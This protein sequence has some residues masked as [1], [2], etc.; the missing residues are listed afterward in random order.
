V[1]AADVAAARAQ[2]AGDG[3]A[4][5]LA[6]AL[7]AA[8]ASLPEAPQLVA[9]MAAAYE[10]GRADALAA[11]GAREPAT[12]PAGGRARLTVLPGGRKEAGR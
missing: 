6:R 2:A 5:A 7:S 1:T 3:V 4:A 8:V 10:T 9:L 12:C 11:L